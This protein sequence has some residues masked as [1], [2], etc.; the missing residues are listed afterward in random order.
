M[1]VNTAF[2]RLKQNESSIGRKIRSELR[3]RILALSD[4]SS[5][6]KDQAPQPGLRL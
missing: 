2:Q 1:P 6:D 4:G 5:I 3:T